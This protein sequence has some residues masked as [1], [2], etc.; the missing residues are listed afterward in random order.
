MYF[1]ININQVLLLE[2]VNR[3]GI[4]L[5]EKQGYE[6]EVLTKSLSAE[7]LKEKIKNVHV[8]GIRSKTQLTEDIL[9]E[10]KELLAIGCFCIGTNQVLLSFL[11][12]VFL[13]A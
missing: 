8:I 5:F 13:I 6:L 4:E 11:L 7:D 10:A 9:K 12:S 2:N 3:T 1:N